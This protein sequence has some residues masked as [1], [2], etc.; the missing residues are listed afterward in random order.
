METTEHF[1][2]NSNQTKAMLKLAKVNSKDIFCDIGCGD[3]I[4]IR[5]AL[6]YAHAKQ[7]IGVES[8][9]T[10]Y[11]TALKSAIRSLPKSQLE[12]IEFWLGN[13][14]NEETTEGK[15]IF[16]YSKVTVVYNSL[17]EDDDEI[18]LYGERFNT[19]KHSLKIVKKDLPLVGYV[20]VSRSEECADCWFFLMRAPLSKYRIGSK[21]KWA[22]SLLGRSNA[23]IED[24]Y[25]YYERQ[26]LN[27]DT[28][29][30]DAKRAVADLKRLVCYRF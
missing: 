23:T 11:L 6:S 21:N 10:N 28:S 14:D 16:D 24:V 5:L 27:R 8:D 20:P 17:N 12:R 3:G 2:L 4:T 13:I 9:Y 29:R 30:K 15:Y 25:D 18:P 19:R 1:F 7:A 26:L 22:V